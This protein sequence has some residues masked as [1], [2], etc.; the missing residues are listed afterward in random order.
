PGSVGG[1]R[2]DG[3]IEREAAATGMSAT[4][5]RSA[6]ASQVS[7]GSFVD[8]DDIAEAVAFLSSPGARFISGQA[9]GVDGHTETLRTICSP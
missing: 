9:L 8:A 5:L 2:M 4:A 3:V 1:A 6:Y 7:M